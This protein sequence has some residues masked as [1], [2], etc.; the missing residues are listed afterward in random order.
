[1]PVLTQPWARVRPGDPRSPAPPPPLL[2]SGCLGPQPAWPRPPRVALRPPPG[3]VPRPRAPSAVRTRLRRRPGAGPAGSGRGPGRHLASRSQARAGCVFS[4]LPA[5]A[6]D[7]AARRPPDSDAWPVSAPPG[8]DDREKLR[9]WRPRRLLPGVDECPEARRAEGPP[10]EGKAPPWSPD[11]PCG[12][13]GPGA[14]PEHPTHCA[15]T[16][17]LLS[18]ALRP[19]AGRAGGACAWKQP[20]QDP[21]PRDS[22]RSAGAGGLHFFFFPGGSYCRLPRPK[23]RA[24]PLPSPRA[25]GGADAPARGQY[26][27][28]PLQAGTSVYLPYRGAIPPA[29][30]Q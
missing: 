8:T 3:L 19:R 28:E 18:A 27:V 30:S 26:L 23:Y 12:P 14:P 15:N 5:A 6:A 9:A 1:M 7:P 4:A 21:G 29:S 16:G 2:P 17:A 20:S 10:G 22:P 11:G 25:G 13:L 24:W